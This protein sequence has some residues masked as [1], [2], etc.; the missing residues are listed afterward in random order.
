MKRTTSSLLRAHS[1]GSL[2]RLIFESEHSNGGGGDDRSI[3]YRLCQLIVIIIR[4]ITP[5]LWFTNDSLFI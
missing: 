4:L 3:P 1:R 2:N 5:I